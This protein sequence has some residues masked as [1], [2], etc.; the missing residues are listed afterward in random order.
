[1]IVRIIFLSVII[2]AVY[3]LMRY[4]FRRMNNVKPPSN[5]KRKSGYDPSKIQDADFEEIK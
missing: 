3:F 1:M 4:I 2:Y 5:Q